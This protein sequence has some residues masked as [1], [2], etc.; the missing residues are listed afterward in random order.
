MEAPKHLDSAPKVPQENFAPESVALA[1]NQM[2]TAAYKKR[3]DKL[4]ITLKSEDFYMKAGLK[5]DNVGSLDSV[6]KAFGLSLRVADISYSGANEK[7][8]ITAAKNNALVAVL[9]WHLENPE[10]SF[11]ESKAQIQQKI[12]KLQK[13]VEEVLNQEKKVPGSYTVDL[14]EGI[15]KVDLLLKDLSVKVAKETDSTRLD[16]YITMLNF[17]ESL[18]SLFG[19]NVPKPTVEPVARMQGSYT[20]DANDVIHLSDSRG[21]N[22]AYKV[23]KP[24]EIQ[25]FASNTASACAVVV[26]DGVSK[27]VLKQDESGKWRSSVFTGVA[28]I[29]DSY[30]VVFGNKITIVKK[31]AKVA[32]AAP[33]KSPEDFHGVLQY[34]SAEWKEWTEGAKKVSTL[35]DKSDGKISCLIELYGDDRVPTENRDLIKTL[36]DGLSIVK[37][38][39]GSWCQSC[40]RIKPFIEEVEKKYTGK[41]KFF[42]AYTSGAAGDVIPYLLQ[43][44]YGVTAFPAFLVFKNGKLQEKIDNIRTFGL[45]GTQTAIDL[46][47]T[48]AIIKKKL[49]SL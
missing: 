23:V 20:I 10:K 44:N 43:K 48:R 45:S 34:G 28:S 29:W 22:F 19:T 9:R 24:P 27:G 32:P 2:K 37:I 49:D 35:M 4:G 16:N 39:G 33:K 8:K 6:N 41:I 18:V 47:K 14:I 38:E 36:G 21:A 3:F 13:R 30:D 7:Y 31:Q 11:D 17:N 5:T 42:T 15:K 26:T 25:L 46:D 1:L 12:V 40:N